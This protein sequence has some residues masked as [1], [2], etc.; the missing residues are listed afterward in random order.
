M[1]DAGLSGRAPQ[2]SFLVPKKP[3]G[4]CRSGER[5]AARTARMPTDV[6]CRHTAVARGVCHVFCLEYADV[7]A[8]LRKDAALHD[9]VRRSLCA[10]GEAEEGVL[11]GAVAK[12]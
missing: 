12:L 3:C 7:Q 2:G 9:R 10:L 4:S 6:Y 11:R 1:S 5:A 8:L